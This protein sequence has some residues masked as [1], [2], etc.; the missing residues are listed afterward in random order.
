[1]GAQKSKP[2]NLNTTGNWE[3]DYSAEVKKCL[4]MS[5]NRITYKKV[6]KLGLHMRF[7]PSPLMK[8][9]NSKIETEEET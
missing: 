1:M 4:P 3:K 7:K 6:E 9:R 2:L 8:Y 5:R